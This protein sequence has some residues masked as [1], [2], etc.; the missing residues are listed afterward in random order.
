MLEG[1]LQRARGSTR[2]QG[3]ACQKVV[4]V[5][6]ESVQCR[7][8]GRSR[9]RGRCRE[10]EQGVGAMLKR[11]VLKRERDGGDVGGGSDIG[12][13]PTRNRC[14][15]NTVQAIGTR[16]TGNRCKSNTVHTRTAHAAAAAGP[17]RGRFAMLAMLM[18]MPPWSLPMEAW[19]M[20]RPSLWRG[21][22]GSSSDPRKYSLSCSGTKAVPEWN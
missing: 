12:T 13:G 10:G 11:G 22:S 3:C 20:V 1:T 5:V 21:S 8:R 6:G 18:C 15:S 7:L 19:L 16:P 14:K 17:H 2:V 9:G 4:V